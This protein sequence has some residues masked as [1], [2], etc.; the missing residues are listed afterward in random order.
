[1][2]APRPRALLISVDNSDACESAVKW[3]MDNL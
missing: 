3:A 1:M 2:A